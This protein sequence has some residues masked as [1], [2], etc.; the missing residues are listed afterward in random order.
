MRTRLAA[1][2]ALLSL[3]AA[4]HAQSIADVSAQLRDKALA[5]SPAFPILESLTTEIGPRPAG[6]PAQ[7][8]AMEWGLAKLTALGFQNVHA[9]PFTVT[10]WVRG[11][12]AAE[13]VAPFPQKLAILGLGGSVPTPKEGIEAEIVLFHT[14]A[15]LLAAPVG[16][17]A[18][19]IAVVT[20][21]MVRTQTGEGYGA[22]NPVRTSGPS[23]AARR[24]AI[25]YLHRSLSTAE[26]RLPHT[27]A[28]RYAPDA[29]KIPAAA[30]SV[31]DAELLDH[32][33]ARGQPIRIRLSLDSHTVPNAPAWNIV[34]EATGREKPDEVIVIGGHL[35]SWDPGTGAIDDGA[36]VSITTGAAKLINDLPRHPRRT[37]RVVMFGSEEMGGAGE[38]YAARHKDEVA[39]IVLAGESDEGPGPVWSVQYPKGALAT[40]AM[41][42]MSGVLAP[43]KVYVGFTPATNSGSDVEGLQILGV[44]VI[45]LH[46]DATRYFDIHHSADDTLDKVDPKALDQS[47]AAWAALIYAAAE[48]DIDFRA[49]A[50]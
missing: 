31:A 32:M 21:P 40:P 47:T 25:A 30:L 26:N 34:G 22:I 1:V 23:E 4:A 38:A 19:K 7:K 33:A 18:G 3:T 36:G 46:P 37:V 45:D 50:K 49:I 42:A 24:G 20:Q 28:L 12:E 41:K 6:S 2:G 29:P 39:K 16:S 9:E 11:P 17:L 14:Y 15:D 43:L 35:D 13:V 27:G 8:R 48:S 44:P 5:G 10:A